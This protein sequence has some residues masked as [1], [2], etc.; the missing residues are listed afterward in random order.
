MRLT[1]NTHFTLEH[2]MDLIDQRS[3]RIQKE[4]KRRVRR[5]LIPLDIQEDIGISNVN[6]DI[7]VM[8]RDDDVFEK[9]QIFLT[10]QG[11]LCDWAETATEGIGFLT[12]ARY[13]LIIYDQTGRSWKITRLMRY[14]NRYLDHVKVIALV[15]D[16]ESGENA[17]A[18]GSFSYV[19]GPNFNERQLQ[20]YLSDLL[21]TPAN[22]N[23]PVETKVG[24]DPHRSKQVDLFD[25]LHH[26]EL[27]SYK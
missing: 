23:F 18:D 21:A 14:V 15:Q 3:H 19:I 7:L 26:L 6:G 4:L 2:W 27:T 17:I 10:G 5:A 12:L 1:P 13:R 11:F 24:T 8:T 16:K 25:E 9:I 22:L 20:Q